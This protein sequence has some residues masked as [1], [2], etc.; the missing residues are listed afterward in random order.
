MAM[1]AD[2]V[3]LMGCL[4]ARVTAWVAAGYLQLGELG[5]R[6]QEMGRGD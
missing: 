4:D 1:D 2:A 6:G 5:S 3:W